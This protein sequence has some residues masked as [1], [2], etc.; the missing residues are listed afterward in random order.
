MT[1][2]LQQSAGSSGTAAV[3]AAVAACC[4]S[5]SGGVPCRRAAAIAGMAGRASRAGRAAVAAPTHGLRPQPPNPESPLA[6]Y[7]SSASPVNQAVASGI[8]FSLR[9][10]QGRADMRL[11]CIWSCKHESRPR[12]QQ[13]V[14]CG[15]MREQRGLPLDAER[16]QQTASGFQAHWVSPATRGGPVPLR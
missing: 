9:E 10:L 3:A 12:A 5:S 11:S 14:A 1:T 6:S 15:Q 13:E 2:R 16:Q 4:H 8:T 7:S